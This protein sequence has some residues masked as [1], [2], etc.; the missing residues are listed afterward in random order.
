MSRMIRKIYDLDEFDVLGLGACLVI[1]KLVWYLSGALLI[2][3]RETQNLFLYYVLMDAAIGAWVGGYLSLATLSDH[4]KSQ[5]MLAKWACWSYTACTIIYLVP[6]LAFGRYYKATRGLEV[7]PMGY[8][9]VFFD[10]YRLATVAAVVA[11]VVLGAMLAQARR[12]KAAA[13]GR[14]DAKAAAQG[15]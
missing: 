9:E 6:F 5:C 7:L 13:E 12:E 2:A 11:V 4:P 3:N 10:A 14:A 15:A 8:D 1:V